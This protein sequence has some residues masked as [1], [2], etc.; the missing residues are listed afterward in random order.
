MVDLVGLGPTPGHLRMKVVV[1]AV[2]FL[3]RTRMEDD[4]ADLQH[5]SR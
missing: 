2:G 1:S 4:G 5:L 3:L